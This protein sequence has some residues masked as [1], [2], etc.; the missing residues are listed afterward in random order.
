MKS[1]FA[2]MALM[3][4]AM[5]SAFRENAY[6]DA[7]MALPTGRGRSRVQ[8]KKQPAGTKLVMRFYKAHHKEKASS[9]EE[10]WGWY[11]N[12]FADLDAAARKKEAQRKE[13]R[14]PTL[15]LAA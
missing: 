12:H 2:M 4:A 11:R 6:R 10:A 5:A 14:K 8:G 15:K 9:V 13:A 7:G 3:A 1:P